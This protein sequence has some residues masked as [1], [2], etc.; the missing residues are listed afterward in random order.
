[1]EGF[2]VSNIYQTPSMKVEIPKSVVDKIVKRA[3]V[4]TLAEWMNLRLRQDA[5]KLL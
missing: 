2:D 1:M 5:V 4:K 3:G